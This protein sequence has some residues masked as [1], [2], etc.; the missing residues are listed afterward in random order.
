MTEINI[1]PCTNTQSAQD[2]DR[3]GPACVSSIQTATG[4][5]RGYKVKR[6]LQHHSYDYRSRFRGYP[7]SRSQHENAILCRAVFVTILALTLTFILLWFVSGT[8]SDEDPS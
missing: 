7:E 3:D 2:D 5:S 6:V 4:F 1:V 8:R